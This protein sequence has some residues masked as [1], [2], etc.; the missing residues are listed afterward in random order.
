M[1]LRR[2]IRTAAALLCLAV[3][4]CIDGKEEYWL[5]RDGSGHAEAC[6]DLPASLLALHGEQDFLH[7]IKAWMLDH[8][9]QLQLD[10]LDADHHGDRTTITVRVSFDNVLRLASLARDPSLASASAS[11]RALVGHLRFDHHGREV[12]FTRTV[13]PK[14]AIGSGR[15]LPKSETTDRHLTYIL[16]LPEPPLESNATRTDDNGRTLIWESSLADAIARQEA[17]GLDVLV[18]GEPATV[19]RAVCI[20]LIVAGIVGLKLFSGAA[21]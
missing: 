4:S 15:L 5:E 6:Y 2:P 19:V 7:S 10:S 17:L 20:L 21:A 9:D 13:R 16:H 1:P 3:S 11:T 8:K 18:H 12:S 14:D